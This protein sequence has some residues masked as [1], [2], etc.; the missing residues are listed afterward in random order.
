M[1]GLRIVT[2]GLG[3]A[4]YNGIVTVGLGSSLL[5]AAVRIIRGGRSVIRD[6]YGDKLEEF[7]IAVSLFAINGKELLKPII[8]KG[9]YVLSEDD[10]SSVK[11]ESGQIKKRNK[12]I[13]SVVVDALK[14][15]RGSDGDN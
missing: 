1:P 6:V 15:K 4:A 11:V 7:K 12:N 2:R 13:F 14:V 5:E 10:K 8:N 3:G 9:K